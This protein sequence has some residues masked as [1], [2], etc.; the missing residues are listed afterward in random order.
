[1]GP[2][3]NRNGK[4]Q[5]L[6]SIAFSLSTLGDFQF[7]GFLEVRTTMSFLVLL[8]IIALVQSLTKIHSP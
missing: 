8:Q 7:A 4:V 6:N 1:M 3:G 5:G 2:D